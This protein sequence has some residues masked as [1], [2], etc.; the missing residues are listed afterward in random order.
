MISILNLSIIT[1]FSDPNLLPF[2]FRNHG[3]VLHLQKVRDRQTRIIFFT[4]DYGKITAWENGKNLHSSGSIGEI[5][6]T[7]K[8]WHNYLKDFEVKKTIFQENWNYNETLAFLQIIQTLYE[9]LPEGVAYQSIF[10][11]LR[12]LIYSLERIWIRYQIFLL[13]HIRI[14]KKLWYLRKELFLSNSR[15]RYIYEN[16]DISDIRNILASSSLDEI[17]I[18]PI[19]KSIIEARHTFLHGA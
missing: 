6:I 5:Y 7:R 8:W 10:L 1:L 11:D 3:I 19:E 13:L 9:A 4:E 12:E 18:H 16:I 2:V 14:L 15:N 17:N